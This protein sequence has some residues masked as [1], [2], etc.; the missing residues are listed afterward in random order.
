M[1][2]EPAIRSPFLSRL[3]AAAVVTLS[4]ALLLCAPAWATGIAA[5]RD[6]LL[7]F[8]HTAWSIERGAP[9]D[10]WDIQ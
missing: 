7:Q 9:A 3:R 5:T 1:P 8:H 4:W 2:H 6:G 10:I